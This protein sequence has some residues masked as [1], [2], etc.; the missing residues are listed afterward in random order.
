[1]MTVKL[2]GLSERIQPNCH[3]TATRIA[4]S[5]ATSPFRNS[6]HSPTIYAPPALT[7]KKW[8]ARCRNISALHAWRY[9]RGIDLRRQR[10]DDNRGIMPTE[11][12][13]RRPESRARGSSSLAA[14]VICSKRLTWL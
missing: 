11:L 13:K 4:E 6:L 8:C 5:T 1:M 7:M 3:L 10:G 9:R 12:C 2:S 14:F